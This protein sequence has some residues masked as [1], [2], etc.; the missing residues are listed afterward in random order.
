LKWKIIAEPER[1]STAKK[2]RLAG[3]KMRYG[4]GATEE[5]IL[6]GMEGGAAQSRP[7]LAALRHALLTGML[8]AR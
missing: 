1:V 7:L 5:R 6:S 2:D 3:A 4:A 8:S